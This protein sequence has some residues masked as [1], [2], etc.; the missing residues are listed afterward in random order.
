M[1]NYLLSLNLKNSWVLESFLGVDKL[2]IGQLLLLLEMVPISIVSI[3]VNTIQEKNKKRKIES[4]KA[5]SVINVISKGLKSLYKS[6]S[7]TVNKEQLSYADC[8]KA[9]NNT[10]EIKYRRTLVSKI[11][12]SYF[13]R[14]VKNWLIDNILSNYATQKLKNGNIP[15]LEII[16]KIEEYRPSSFYDVEK[17]QIFV[18]Y[19]L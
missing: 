10:D 2:Y 8:I 5:K 13:I 17:S 16:P 9:I 6:I 3:I 7:A 18:S 1:K 12:A 11:L 19:K 15:S 4:L 14:D